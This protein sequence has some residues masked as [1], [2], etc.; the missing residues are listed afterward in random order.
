VPQTAHLFGGSIADN[1]RLGDRGASDAAV[2]R[3]AERAGLAPLMAAHPEGIH[4][5]VGERG[6]LL[7]T[8]Q[9]QRVAIARALVRDPALLLLDEPAAHLDA[10]TAGDVLAGITSFGERRTLIVVTHD[11]VWAA[12]ADRV[13][14]LQDGRLAP[15]R[16]PVPV[17]GER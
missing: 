8:G 1:I 6:S 4:A 9:R 17:G 15:E 5:T 11:P 16:A 12:G 13:L 2:A 14:R 10:E 7:S 3:A